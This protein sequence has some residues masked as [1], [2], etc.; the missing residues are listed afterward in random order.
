MKTG[1][2]W[3]LREHVRLLKPLFAVIAAVWTLRWV[4][5]AAGCPMEI[6]RILSVT[7]VSPLVILLATL[8]IHHKNFGGY[9]SVTLSSFLLVAWAQLLTVA[10][11]LFAVLT[12]S[13]N[14]Y[15]VPEFSFPNDP[16]H[17]YHMLSHITAI[18]LVGLL[19]AA[20]AC[21]MLWILRVFVPRPNAKS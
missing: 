17:V 18:L 21:L 4:A 1:C 7:A 11:I 13:P 8:L 16:H 3:R 2:G 10:A 20:M 15:S 9:A 12:G 19:G 5:A 6:V 14:V